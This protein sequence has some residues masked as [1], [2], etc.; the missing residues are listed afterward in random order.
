[1]LNT[2]CHQL[3]VVYEKWYENKG[4]RIHRMKKTLDVDHYKGVITEKTR[5][6]DEAFQR[7]TA[8]RFDI[9]LRASLNPLR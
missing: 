8:S 5:E 2:V 7:Y 4:A 9:A 1:M 6:L 3:D